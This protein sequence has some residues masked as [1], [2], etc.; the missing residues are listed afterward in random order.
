MKRLFPYLAVSVAVILFPLASLGVENGTIT[1]GSIPLMKGPSFIVEDV[2]GLAT[3]KGQRVEVLSRTS[4]TDYLAAVP[5]SYWYNVRL[6]RGGSPV[7]GYIHGSILL[8]DPGVTVPVFDP[9]GYAPKPKDVSGGYTV[10]SAV[11]ERCVKT[12]GILTVPKGSTATHFTIVRFDSSFTP[13]PDGGYGS[14]IGFS[15]VPAADRNREFFSY[16]ESIADDPAGI[17]YLKDGFYYMDLDP[18]TYVVTVRG[19]PGTILEITYDLM[20]AR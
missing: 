12:E 18:G 20:V 8:V 6:A 5:E 1:E 2:P 13:C 19:G 16:E 17:Q 15:I 11:S 4:F 7:T 9:P 10:K 14:V 3:V